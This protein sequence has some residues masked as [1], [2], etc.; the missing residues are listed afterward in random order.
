MDDVRHAVGL[1]G[2]LSLDAVTEGVRRILLF[3]DPW[4]ARP[5]SEK[6][7]R[8]IAASHTSQ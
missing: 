5:A 8:A 7:C 2:T 3:K 4:M 1:S 6:E